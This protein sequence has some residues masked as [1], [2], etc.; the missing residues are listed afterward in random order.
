MVGK[1]READFGW[2]GSKFQCK[3][4]IPTVKKQESAAAFNVHAFATKTPVFNEIK[5]ISQLFYRFQSARFCI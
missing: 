2:N 3:S 1:I 5:G 4:A